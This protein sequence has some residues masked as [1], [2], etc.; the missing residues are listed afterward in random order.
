MY[1]PNPEHDFGFDETT[2]FDYTHGECW[3]LALAL[4]QEAGLPVVALWG[5]D[6]IQH[7]G[8][9]LP[10]GDIVDI[11]GVWSESAWQSFWHEEISDC[12]G[13]YFDDITMADEGWRDAVNAYSVDMLTQTIA[14]TLPLGEIVEHIIADLRSRKLIAQ[15][16]A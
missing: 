4:Q 12:D 8:V 15:S 7:V 13:V 2:V 11:E 6:E 16:A 9:E 10:N 3:Y 5:N 1:S 14:G